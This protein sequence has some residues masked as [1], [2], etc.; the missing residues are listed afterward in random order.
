MSRRALR[1]IHP[2]DLRDH[3]D[4]DRIARIWE[5]IEHDISIPEAPPARGVGF[6]FALVAATVAA[7]AGGLFIGRVTGTDP[8]ATPIYPLTPE[9]SAGFEVLAAG[10][11]ERTVALPGGGQ[12]KLSPGAT[13]EVGRSDHNTLTIMLVQG[14][15]AID[16]TGA[17][18]DAALAIVAGQARLQSHAG[19]VVSVQRNASNI[20]VRVTS[21]L[22]SVTS[23]DGIEQQIAGGQPQITV[24][25]RTST[26]VT[27]NDPVRPR[28]QMMR[29]SLPDEQDPVAEPPA[30]PVAAAPD[31]RGRCH[32]GDF[33]GAL[34]ILR[35]QPGGIASAIQSAQSA[36][37]LMCISDAAQTGGEQGAAI[38]ALT[39]V[40]D[41]FA[42]DN[43]APFAAIQ[44]ARIYQGAKNTELAEKYLALSRSLAPDGALAEVALCRQIR[45]E[46]K[47]GRKEEASRMAR[48]YVAK[49]PDGSCKE[50]VE[51]IIQGEEPAPDEQEPEAPGDAK[52][53][54]AR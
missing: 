21:G 40:T 1:S 28:A 11:A 54:P 17:T 8:S 15:A 24:P 10:T 30:A 3:A 44:L 45:A 12:I 5:R 43:N 9:A 51:R 16:T 29:P 22:V 34:D 42:A 13:V 37:E 36:G 35:Q 18:T 7:F 31:W 20:G 52:N 2:E 23:P 50:D 47:K 46:A 4:E 39:R 33:A 32:D 53:A 41:K 26:V 6:T 14:T 38:Q 25:L 48:E 19:S 27:M 49:Y